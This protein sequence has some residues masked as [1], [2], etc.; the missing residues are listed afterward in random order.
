MNLRS[1][2]CHEKKHPFN[3]LLLF[4]VIDELYVV[5]KFFELKYN[6]KKT[7]QKMY[8][9]NVFLSLLTLG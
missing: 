3:I 5:I 2:Q 1:E 6:F 8:T 7:R 9:I 4:M